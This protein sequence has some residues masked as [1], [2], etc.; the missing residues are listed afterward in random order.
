[1]AGVTLRTQPASKLAPAPGPR[2]QSF[3]DQIFLQGSVITDDDQS[4]EGYVWMEAQPPVDPSAKSGGPQWKS[5]A[6]RRLVRT[7]IN[8]LK[9]EDRNDGRSLEWNI[10]EP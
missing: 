6:V 5:G 1:M 4:A 9:V 10:V 7:W 8:S 2:N 3:E